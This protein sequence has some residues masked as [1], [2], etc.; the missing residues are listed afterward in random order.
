MIVMIRYAPCRKSG[1]GFFLHRMKGAKEIIRNGEGMTFYK[2]TDKF[3]FRK[4]KVCR[5]LCGALLGTVAVAGLATNATSVKADETPISSTVGTVVPAS[6]TNVDTRT[7]VS[8]VA[9]AISNPT[10]TTEVAKAVADQ[11]SASSQKQPT[12]QL[13]DS[14]LTT[15]SE[16]IAEPVTEESSPKTP[17]V[18]EPV[19]QTSTASKPAA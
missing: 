6:K 3:G 17:E 2:K 16:M 18:P 8:T 7:E 14:S 1:E 5:S 4:S 10:A 15:K 9:K 12:R 19:A 11:D 13:S